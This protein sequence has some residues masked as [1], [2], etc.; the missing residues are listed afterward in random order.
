[1]ARRVRITVVKRLLNEDLVEKYAPGPVETCGRMKEGDVFIT[2]GRSCPDNFCTW[3]WADIF[4]DILLVRQDAVCYTADRK[5]MVTACT[6]GLRPVI[7]L[8]EPCE[9]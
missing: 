7:F 9:E 5:G 8:V 3:A 2:D 6:D 1:M 4:K